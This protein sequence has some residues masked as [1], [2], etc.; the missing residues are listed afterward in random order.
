MGEAWQR[1]HKCLSNVSERLTL[2]SDGE[3]KLF[4]DSLVGNAH[5]LIELLTHLNITKDPK[6]EQARIELNEAIGHHDADSLRRSV[7]AKEAV[8]SKVDSILSKFEF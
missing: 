7:V 8:K 1:L 4:R 3:E 2:N 5:E 6:L